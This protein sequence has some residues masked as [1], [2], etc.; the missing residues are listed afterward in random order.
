MRAKPHRSRAEGFV[1]LWRIVLRAASLI[2]LGIL[3]ATGPAAAPR[4]QQ[5]AAQPG[6]TVP[7]SRQ[8][9]NVAIITISGPIDRYTEVSFKR[10]LK[11]AEQAGANALVVDLHTPGGE[12]GAVLEICNAIKGSTISNTVAWIDHDA[13]SGG[14]IIALACSQIVVNRPASMG[15]ALPIFAPLGVL[16][17]MN[18][19]EREKILA[20]LLAE[21]TDSARRNGYDEKLVQGM[22]S[23]GVELWLVENTNTGQRL[24]IDRR[25]HHMLFGDPPA[26]ESPAIASGG[27]DARQRQAPADDQ[28][29]PPST[30]DELA[31]QPA[32]PELAGEEMIRSITAAQELAS[33]R[34][35][36]SEADR[37]EWVKIEYVTRGE[38]PIV[39]KADQLLSY[40]LAS[41]T[42][43]NDE[44]L[45]AYFG[46]QNLTRLDRSWSEAMVRW[47]TQIWVRGILIAIFLIGMFMEMSSP[48]IAA[49]G[50][51]SAIA[52]ALFLI[53]PMLTGMADWW[54][55]AAMGAGVVLL[56]LEVFVIPGFGLPGVIG[57]ILLFFGMVAT[58]VPNSG[59]LF[60]DS[61]TQREDM[62]W[63][64]ATVILA[65]FTSGVA[66]YYLSKHFQ[67]LPMLNRLI[68]KDEPPG[69]R[70]SSML[71]AM[72][73]GDAEAIGIGAE[74]RTITPLYPVGRAEFG[75]RIIDVESSL[76]YVERGTP[77]RIVATGDLGR[78]IVEPIESEG[79]ATA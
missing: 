61:P 74:G 4:A 66:M 63:G 12:V 70:A 50:I 36:L 45:K 65:L 18:D 9:K 56:A 22:V 7:A 1:G 67:S 21:V 46:A 47:L 14:A 38:G 78:L 19:E 29:P 49:P 75:D 23:L 55:I 62:L 5:D 33:R 73:P 64:A 10:R 39:L 32:A 8:A 53:P 43:R 77:V 20:P 54:E 40:N 57:L 60:P 26:G 13:Y 37:G 30:D 17:E 69:E 59:R 79:D 31:V 41:A 44:E 51:A 42:I 15:D 72:R 24:F 58:F 11:L 16:M 35:V 27:G 68:L 3:A 25:E 52:L 2:S 76:G 34:P 48:G 6:P 28:S 71:M